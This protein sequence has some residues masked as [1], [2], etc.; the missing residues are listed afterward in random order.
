MH[1]AIGG[2]QDDACFPHTTHIGVHAAGAAWTSGRRTEKDVVHGSITRNGEAHV[3]Q[4]QQKVAQHVAPYASRCRDAGGTSNT[5][6]N[7]SDQAG[8]SD[9][10]TY[11]HV[12]CA[13]YFSDAKA[14]GRQWV[15]KQDHPR[16]T[17][18]DQAGTRA[19]DADRWD[20]SVEHHR[21]NSVA[22]VIGYA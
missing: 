8:I 2:Q 1:T 22:K 10:R 12:G 20:G 18:L 14:T 19:G 16:F 7:G 21:D 17:G 15:A 11:R 5:D 13:E 3:R 4:K 6:S 9:G